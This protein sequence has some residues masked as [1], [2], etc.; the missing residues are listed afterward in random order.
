[1]SISKEASI[2]ANLDAA[3]KPKSIAI[4]GASND[5]NKLGGSEVKLLLDAN[6]EGPIY[7]INPKEEEI[8]G[9]KAYKSVLNVPNQ[10]DRATIILP[11]KLVPQAV[12]ECAEK[13]VKV[14]QIYSAGFSEFGEKGKQ[15]ENQVLEYAKKHN[16]RIIGPNC[17]GT[18]S[19]SGRITFVKGMSM[20]PGNVAFVS[21]SGGITFDIVNRGELSG[22]KFSKA[23]SIGNSIDLEHADYLNYLN[24]DPAT[25]VIG[26]YVE[27]VRDGQKFFKALKQATVNKPVIILKGG[28]TEV[29]SE[30]VVSH[31]GSIA[32]D[33]RIWQSLFEQTGAYQV[34]SIEEMITAL[35]CLQNLTRYPTARVALIGNGGGATVLATDYLA[36]LQLP[37][38]NISPHT[39]KKLEEMGVANNGRNVN[40]IDLPAHELMSHDGEKFGKLV[41]LLTTEE[42]VDYVLFHINLVPFASYFNLED[43]LEKITHQLLQLNHTTTNLIGAF[44]TNGDPELEKIRFEAV[45]TLGENGIPVFRSFEEAAFGISILSS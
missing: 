39:S 17:I 9:L 36:E 26:L 30:S 7:P 45:K 5:L 37:L 40:P 10:I 42:E 44:R 20:D 19:P 6:F 22:I 12:K 11:P 27:S 38:G 29:G 23:I 4:I 3:F 24:N 32:G 16:T 13:K 34:K 41:Q 15:L 21:Q 31:T 8:Q 1:L 43:I 18:Y 14:V 35:V 33:Y 25:K 2:D 28:R